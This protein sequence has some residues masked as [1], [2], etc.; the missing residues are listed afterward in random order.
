M[1]AEPREP[2]HCE[3]FFNDNQHL[4]VVDYGWNCC[5]GAI[6]KLLAMISIDNMTAP[7]E[8][9]FRMADTFTS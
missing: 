3:Y 6:P 2:E 9:N 7:K 5:S 1:R 8:K 4:L